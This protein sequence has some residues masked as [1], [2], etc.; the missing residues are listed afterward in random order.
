MLIAHVCSAFVFASSYIRKWV[1]DCLVK[2]INSLLAKL[3]LDWRNDV[4]FF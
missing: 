1:D 2:K 3:M 4:G